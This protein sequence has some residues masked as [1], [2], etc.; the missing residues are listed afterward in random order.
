MVY[1]PQLINE[2]AFRPHVILST[3]FNRIALAGVQTAMVYDLFAHQRESIY[4]PCYIYS[5]HLLHHLDCI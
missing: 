4:T 2:K 3:T 1:D 5:I